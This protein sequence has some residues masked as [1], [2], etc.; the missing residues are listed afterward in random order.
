MPVDLLT[1]ADYMAD[2]Q[3]PV[4]DDGRGMLSAPDRDILQYREML[5]AL[6]P[7]PPV[8]HY[9]AD[10]VQQ[11]KFFDDVLDVGGRLT[12]NFS[13]D[14]M[15]YVGAAI[16]RGQGLAE[17]GTTS[18]TLDAPG[19]AFL[20]LSKEAT[21]EYWDW[22]A[23]KVVKTPERWGGALSL[24]EFL[25]ADML[26]QRPAMATPAGRAMWAGAD[27]VVFT[28]IT[29]EIPRNSQFWNESWSGPRPA[30]I[31]DPREVWTQAGP[32]L[33]SV[34]FWE[35]SLRFV[36]A[37]LVVWPRQPIAA[38]SGKVMAFRSAE[39]LEKWA[40]VLA[41]RRSVERERVEG[42]A[43]EAQSAFARRKILDLHDYAARFET[44]ADAVERRVAW[45]SA[46]L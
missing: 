31:Y 23:L 17:T 24:K 41:K 10:F 36:Q 22:Q 11:G 6:P 30:F 45:W 15:K 20:G 9:A 35:Y 38:A 19:P 4:F 12:N 37:V 25:I 3:A 2:G 18:P 28:D 29:R 1:A 42:M 7:I 32:G 14:D 39:T 16:L 44:V 26:E 5:Y 43:R 8:Q 27:L 13:R 34:S 46:F 40:G 33:W 21:V